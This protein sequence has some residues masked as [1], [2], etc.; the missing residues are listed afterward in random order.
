[1]NPNGRITAR[2]EDFMVL[3]ERDLAH[4]SFPVSK[5]WRLA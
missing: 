4:G 5:I 3:D 1:M 2:V